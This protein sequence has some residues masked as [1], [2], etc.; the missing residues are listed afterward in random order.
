MHAY[1][2]MQSK[3]PTFAETD[4]Q[5]LLKRHLARKEKARLRMR[6]KRAE[7]K[8]RPKDEQVAANARQRGY[9]TKYRSKRREK[10]RLLQH[11]RRL[12]AYKAIHGPD[13]FADYCRGMQERR[14]TAE[15]RARAGE[16]YDSDMDD[17]EDELCSSEDESDGRESSWS[18]VP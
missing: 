14:Q 11:Q 8:T 10:L 6:R 2:P 4:Y 16:P 1:P 9:Q 17:F 7:L 13:V 5:A 18:P 15:C 3:F 12:D